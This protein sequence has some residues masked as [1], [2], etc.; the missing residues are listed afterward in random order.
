MSAKKRKIGI[1]IWICVV[2]AL[3][4]AGI[5]TGNGGEEESIKVV[6][7]DAVL[8]ETGKISLFGIMEV[9]PAMNSGFW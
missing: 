4:V 5:L 8:H 6:M 1:A 9:N 2:L 3:L 7:R